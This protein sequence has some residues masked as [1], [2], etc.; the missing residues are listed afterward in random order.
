MN[1]VSLLYFHIYSEY[2]ITMVQEKQ[3]RIKIVIENISWKSVLML[4]T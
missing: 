2:A 3:E 1:V 4:K